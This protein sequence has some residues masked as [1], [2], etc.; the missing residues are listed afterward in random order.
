MHVWLRRGTLALAIVLAAS[1]FARPAM[2]NQSIEPSHAIQAYL[3]EASQV[4]TIINRSCRDCHSNST[5]WPWTSRVAPAS[6]LIAHDVTEGRE[7][8]NFSEWGTYE[9]SKQGKLLKEACKE[10][11]DGDMPPLSYTFMHP[12]AKMTRQD[13]DAICGAAPQRATLR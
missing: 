5:V 10:V 13:V 6:W 9:S 4:V 12:D 7:A 3:P 2:T 8:V 11:K 1:Q